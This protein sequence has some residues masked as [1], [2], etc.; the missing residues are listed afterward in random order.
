ME[1][2]SLWLCICFFSRIHNYNVHLLHLSQLAPWYS[3]HLLEN[4]ICDA[5]EDSIL[6]FRKKSCHIPRASS[7]SSPKR[8]PDSRDI[9][10]RRRLKRWL[11]RILFDG[12]RFDDP[13]RMCIWW[14]RR[15][16]KR[17]EKNHYLML[18]CI[19]Q[20]TLIFSI[21]NTQLWKRRYT[22]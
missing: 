2:S 10:N 1:N 4:G 14:K 22:L 13:T 6:R 16:I 17:V 19:L 20:L 21:R 9:R 18:I 12:K 5:C 7:S 11:S 15:L 8:F 3:N